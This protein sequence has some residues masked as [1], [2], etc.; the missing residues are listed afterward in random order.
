MQICIIR[1]SWYSCKR[2]LFLVQGDILTFDEFSAYMDEFRAMN[3][4]L[5]AYGRNVACLGRTEVWK[6]VAIKL[7]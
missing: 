4:S 1:R 7:S 3:D 5:G 6:Q 2:S